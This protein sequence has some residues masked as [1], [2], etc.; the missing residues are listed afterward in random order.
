MPVSLFPTSLPVPNDSNSRVA[1]RNGDQ[2]SDLLGCALSIADSNDVHSVAPE[3]F[4]VFS[5]NQY[6][7]TSRETPFE[8][9]Q[10]MPSCSHDWCLCAWTWAVS[11]PAQTK[12][13]AEKLC[14]LDFR[15]LQG[16]NSAN[17]MY[18]VGFKCK[19]TGV[20]EGVQLL[21]AG[22]QNARNPW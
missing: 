10:A 21:P 13:C 16:Q 3:D 14:S 12:M 17:E 4:I 5:V 22:E 2:W 15:H 7:V 6:C 18:Q 1:A 11:V 19:P 20:G 8:V 9:P